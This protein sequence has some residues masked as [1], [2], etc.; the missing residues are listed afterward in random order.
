MLERDYPPLTPMVEDEE[1][2]DEVEDLGEKDKSKEKVV[3]E[4]D[5]EGK[6]DKPKRE[7]PSE[8]EFI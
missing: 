6:T 3:E 5:L 8:G 4:E 7:E 2:E 1:K